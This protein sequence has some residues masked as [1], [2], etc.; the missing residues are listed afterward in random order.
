MPLT[1]APDDRHLASYLLGLLPEEEA[2]RLDE[3]S[4][5]DDELAS[6]LCGVEDDLVDAYVS[7]TLDQNTR[8]HF[9]A[10]YLKS[11]RRRERVKFAKRFLTAVDRASAVSVPA[12]VAV[13]AVAGSDRVRRFTPRLEAAKPTARRSRLNWPAWTAAA[14]LVLACGVIVKD[15]RL[16]E[17]LHLAQQQGASQDRQAEMLK[18]QLDEARNE[19]AQIAEALER[20]RVASTSRERVPVATPS[21]AASALA[22]VTV[23]AVVLFMQ[24]RSTGQP[25]TVDVPP[26]AS[27]IPFEL[28]LESNDFAQFRALL[29][30]PASTRIVWRSAALYA[31]S[32]G[33]S[34]VPVVVPASALESRHYA[35]ELAGIDVAGNETTIGNYAVQIDRR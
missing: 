15:L 7:E 12:A 13:A 1:L 23:K 19:N 21:G 22:A 31:R 6:R 11:P 20:A 24:T 34:V 4:V 10:F 25:P 32:N 35:F 16:R 9:E 17:G 27:A 2:E 30:D 8:D 33:S 14:S 18:R 28:R 26:G 3:A 5:V 29:R